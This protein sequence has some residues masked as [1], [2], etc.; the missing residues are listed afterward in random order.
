M[1][2]KFGEKLRKEGM[3]FGSTTGRPRRCGWIDIPQLLYTIMLNGVTQIII[4]K[5]DVLDTFDKISVG[6][7]YKY[8]D[9][10]SDELPFDMVNL[11]IDP[12]YE[13]NEGWNQSLNDVTSYSKLPPKAIKYIDHLGKLLK[14]RISMVST[15]PEREKLLKVS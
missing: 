8:D 1:S 9:K 3:E 11:S 13:E 2:E 14:T 6:T 15:G 10:I 7:S 5:L 4:T 12:V